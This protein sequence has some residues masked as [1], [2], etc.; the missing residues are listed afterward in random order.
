MES[1]A[2]PVESRS[3]LAPAALAVA[4]STVLNVVGVF[5]EDEIHWVNLFVGFA[6]AVAGA[7]VVFGWL[8]RRALRRGPGAWKTAIG[9]AVVGLLSLAAYWSNL[10]PILGVAAA[11]LGHASRDGDSTPVARRAGAVAIGLGALVLIVDVVL[12]ATDVAS[13]T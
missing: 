13:R 4:L 8:A 2:M 10:P 3:V 12:Y 5:S 11:Y 1:A 9:V 6:L 7:A